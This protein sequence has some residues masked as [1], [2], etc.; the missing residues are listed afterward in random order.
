MDLRILPVKYLIST[1]SLLQMKKTGGLVLNGLLMAFG[2]GYVVT[3][4]WGL[5]IGRQ[6][7]MSRDM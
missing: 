7:N 5:Q 1:N 2:H 6:V 4:L 3:L